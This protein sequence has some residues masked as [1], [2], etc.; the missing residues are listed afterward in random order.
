M[1]RIDEAM[2]QAGVR[3]LQPA[4]STPPNG[5]LDEFPRDADVGRPSPAFES[6]SSAEMLPDFPADSDAAPP[7]P[8]RQVHHRPDPPAPPVV[9]GT[10]DSAIFGRLI[11]HDAL[12]R[13]AVEQYRR[14]AGVLH[15]TQVKQGTRTVMV[16]SA[17]P[18]EGKTLTAVNL[19]LTLSESYHRKVLLIDADLRRPSL[20]QLF[21]QTHTAGLGET[22]KAADNRA[23]HVAPLTPW[24]SLL[25]GGAADANPMAGL[26]SSRMQQILKEA[27]ATFEWVVLDTPPVVQLPD[28]HLLAAMVDCAVLV[29]NA[30]AT[31]CSMVQRTIDRIGRAKIAGV[32]LN[33]VEKAA[34]KEASYYH[35]ASA[36]VHAPAASDAR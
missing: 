28:T 35:Y 18:A 3:V 26:T 21:Q 1:I 7:V 5:V 10:V 12:E 9:P 31:P 8:K 32:V 14:L 29:I 36:A 11:V 23:L 19:A 20:G 34:L 4:A 25:P 6:R 22:L 27:A 16:V 24:L 17:Q 15:Q 13:V 30:G 33:R 2:R